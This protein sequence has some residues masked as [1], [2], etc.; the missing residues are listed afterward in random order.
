MA[1]WDDVDLGTPV[2]GGGKDPETGITWN[3]AGVP[4]GGVSSDVLE[5]HSPDV[6]A[7][8]ATAASS[9]FEQFAAQYELDEDG[10]VKGTRQPD[11]SGGWTPWHGQRA[12]AP[13]SSPLPI[14]C[15][16]VN[17]SASPASK[18]TRIP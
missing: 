5:A 4:V 17:A 13:D 1:W 12:R 6:Q 9:E 11:G 2:V 8:T 10:Y 7:T 3:A 15:A 16:T 18:S 14:L